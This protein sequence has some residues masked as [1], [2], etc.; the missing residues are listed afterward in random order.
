MLA[1]ADDLITYR[2]ES[3]L[4]E[5]ATMSLCELPEDETI[6]PDEFLK[7]TQVIH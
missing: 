4:D 1:R 2:I 6:S 7:K 5:I 3:A